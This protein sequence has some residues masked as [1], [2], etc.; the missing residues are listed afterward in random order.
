MVPEF[1]GV[2]TDGI[3]TFGWT[4]L[5]LVSSNPGGADVKG[6]AMTLDTPAVLWEYDLKPSGPLAMRPKSASCTRLPAGPMPTTQIVP[7]ADRRAEDDRQ[8]VIVR[9][10]LELPRPLGLIMGMMFVA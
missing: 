1:L 6:S 8:W 7:T 10:T 2:L 9:A 3:P 5:S 4:G